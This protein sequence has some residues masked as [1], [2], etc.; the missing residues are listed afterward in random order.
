MVTLTDALERSVAAAP[1]DA[2]D[3][4][5]LALARRLA[6]E[7]DEGG[8]LPKLAPQFLAA[9]AALGM[10]L[11]ARSGTTQGVAVASPAVDAL[12]DLRKRRAAR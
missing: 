6:V 1:V 12:A 10:T 5:A 8:E 9:L 2:R 3:E 4:A 7:I 11:S